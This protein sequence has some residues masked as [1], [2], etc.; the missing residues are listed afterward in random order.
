MPHPKDM[1]KHSGYFV[2][3]DTS[4]RVAWRCD[5][6]VDKK[7]VNSSVLKH[8]FLEGVEQSK[9]SPKKPGNTFSDA[10]QMSRFQNFAADAAKK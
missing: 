4:E 2:W 6:T 1:T 8:L 3:K 9:K 7:R 5:D 10:L